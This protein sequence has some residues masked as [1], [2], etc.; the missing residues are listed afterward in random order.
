MPKRILPPPRC[1]WHTRI[2]EKVTPSGAF[3]SGFD[4]VPDHQ[5]TIRLEGARYISSD[6]FTP[7]VSYHSG[8]FRGGMLQR[9]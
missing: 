8:K 6:F 1:I 5:M 3:D 7:K 4:R 2:W 9:R